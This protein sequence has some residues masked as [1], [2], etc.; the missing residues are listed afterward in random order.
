MLTS[1]PEPIFTFVRRPACP[2]CGYPSYSLAGVHPQCASV[3]ADK[4]QIARTA[5][6]IAA[7]AAQPRRKRHERR[8]PNYPTS[9]VSSIP[10]DFRKDGATMADFVMRTY[11]LTPCAATPTTRNEG[12]DFRARDDEDAIVQSLQIMESKAWISGK[13]F[14]KDEHIGMIPVAELPANK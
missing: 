8:R 14:F 1:K 9:P 7:K 6:K 11:R 12:M 10:N 5:A 13:L 4:I 3:A 2:V